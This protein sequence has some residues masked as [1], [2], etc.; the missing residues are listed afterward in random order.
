MQQVE[1][2]CLIDT[3]HSECIVCMCNY[4]ANI[5]IYSVVKEDACNSRN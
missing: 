2:A 4:S 3:C 5:G 1:S